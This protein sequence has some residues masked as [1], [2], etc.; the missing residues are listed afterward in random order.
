VT[1]DQAPLP[2]N[3]GGQGGR[4]PLLAVD[5]VSKAFGGL[6]AVQGLSFQ[7]EA[8]EILGLI[9]PNGAGK[10]TAFNVISGFYEPTAGDVRFKEESVV[11]R[12]PHQI[13]LRGLTRTFQIV[14]PFANLTVLENVMVGAFARTDAAGEARRAADEVLDFV[15]LSPFRDYPARG[16]TLA[17]RKRLEVAKALATRPELLLLDE[18]MAG[19]NPRE[20]A[21]VVD[22]LRRVRD[23]GTSIL[24]IE[25][26]MH[27]IMRLCD[28]ILVIHHG[29]QIA[30]G[31]PREIARDQRVVEAYLGE[32]Y[33]LAAD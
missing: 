1:D 20:V 22:L 18:V 13:C 16:L 26:V 10:T 21:E 27:A 17:G 29:Q 14:Q 23:E 4:S 11:G 33:L 9:G 12:K 7:M 24:V 2:P 8:G 31:P 15:G 19:L 28:R 3:H 30:E 6:V 5:H 32:E 25:H